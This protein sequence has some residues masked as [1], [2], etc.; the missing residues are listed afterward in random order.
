MLFIRAESL[1]NYAFLTYM[2]LVGNQS[3]QSKQDGVER[4]IFVANYVLILHAYH[5]N[6]NWCLYGAMSRPATI[7]TSL[8]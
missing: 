5:R 7:S 4:Q 1:L 8:C 6:R 2:I 3:E